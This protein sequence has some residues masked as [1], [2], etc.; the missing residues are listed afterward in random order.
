MGGSKPEPSAS[1]TPA[2]ASAPPKKGFFQRANEVLSAP[3]DDNAVGRY[4]ND[5]IDNP[6]LTG[7]EKA[8]Q[9]GAVLASSVR[10]KEATAESIAAAQKAMP[11]EPEYLKQADEVFKQAHG[12]LGVLDA[13]VSN[14]RAVLAKSIQGMVQGGGVLGAS[15]GAG[16][17]AGGGVASLL[18][19]AAGGAG[20]GYLDTYAETVLSTLQAH[21]VDLSSKDAVLQA[22]N[23][24]ALMSAASVAA[25]KAG[26]PSAIINGLSFGLA[27]RIAGP[28]AGIVGRGIAGRA[29]GAGAE[30][31]AQG[32]IGAGGE[33]GTQLAQQGAI[34]NPN[35]IAQAGVSQAALTAPFVAHGVFHAGEHGPAPQPGVEP[36]QAAGAPETANAPL[37]PTTEADRQAALSRA[38]Q[39]GGL[40]QDAEHEEAL[41]PNAQEREVARSA[42][43][44]HF[45][46]LAAVDQA[47][48][49]A[50]RAVTEAGPANAI[51]H[52]QRDAAAHV[53]AQG[54][55][56]LS[57]VVAATHA[58]AV[59]GGVHDAAAVQGA[60][61]ATALSHQQQADANA[62]AAMSQ[63]PS[64]DDAFALREAQQVQQRDRDF[65]AAKNQVGDQAIEAGD[66]SMI[67]ADRGGANE[68]KPTLA[69]ALPPE[70]LTALQS[71]KARRAAEMAQPQPEPT[72]VER[73]KAQAKGTEDDV[74]ELPPAAPPKNRLAAIRAAVEKRQAAQPPKVAEPTKAAEPVKSTAEPAE[75]EE[76]PASNPPAMTPKTLADRRQAQM[77][78]A[79]SAKVRGKVHEAPQEVEDRARSEGGDQARI[80]FL[81]SE[82]EATS[83]NDPDYESIKEELR[84]M[85][86]AP[87]E[88]APVA[89][90]DNPAA[91]EALETRA[92]A[93][94]PASEEAA[95]PAPRKTLALADRR[96]QRQFISDQKGR[97]RFADS[98]T[99]PRPEDVQ[100]TA[101]PDGTHVA[102][103]QNGRTVAA[104]HPNGTDLQVKSSTRPSAR[105]RDEAPARLE[106]LAQ[107]A[108]DRGGSLESG[109]RVSAPDQEAYRALSDRGYP[110]DERSNTTDPKT[111]AK[112]STSTDGV[113]RVGPR[114]MTQLNGLQLR[115]LAHTGDPVARA[116]MDRR[117]NALPSEPRGGTPEAQYVARNRDTGEE[118]ARYSNTQDANDHAQRFPQDRVAQEAPE[119]PAL[120]AKRNAFRDTQPGERRGAP[121]TK[122][123][124]TQRLQPLI[125]HVGPDRLQVHDGLQDPTVP[126]NVRDDAARYNHPDPR[127]A[128]DPK[129]GAVH[130]F[131]GA[132]GH[133]DLESLHDT[134]IHEMAHRGIRSFLGPDYADTMQ[135]VFDN[136]HDRAGA[137]RSP[138]AGVA[139]T[140]ARNW[141]E[142]YISQH[143]MDPKNPGHQQIAADEYVASIAEHDAND[144]R[145]RNP[146]ILRKVYD[147]V[148]AGLRKVGVVHEWT[149]NDIRRLL[150]ES[151]NNP[152][153]PHA[154]AAMED[155]GNGIRWADS[156]DR[157]VERLPPEDPRAIAAKYQRALADSANYNP[158]YVKSRVDALAR[159]KDFLPDWADH[160]WE[161][162]KDGGRRLWL[163]SIPLDKL[164]D[165]VNPDLNPSVRRYVRTVR[166][167]NGRIGEQ[168]AAAHEIYK[169]WNEFAQREPERAASLDD[170]MHESTLAG[171]DP[172]KPFEN[173]FTDEQRARSPKKTAADAARKARYDEMRPR[174]EAL[175]DEGQKIYRDVRD[176]YKQ[177]RADHDA[178]LEQRMKDLG[179][180]DARSKQLMS[181][182]Q[183]DTHES[184]RVPEPYFPLARWG[185]RYAVA[186]LAG[187]DEVH[188]Y[189]RFET[190][191]QQKQWAD[192]M[193]AE[194]HDVTE[195]RDT[196]SN[197]AAS[198]GV[199]PVFLH[200]V[201]EL[202]K[203]FEPKEGSEDSSVADEIYQHYLQSL[204]DR[205]YRKMFMHRTGRLGFAGNARRAFADQSIRH[206]KAVAS[207]EYGHRLDATLENVSTEQK[208]IAQLASSNPG[209]R[210]LQREAAW[211][212]DIRNELQNR[213][214][215]I[216]NPGSNR[217][218]NALTGFGF[219]YYL[220]FNPATAA[221]IHT[222]QYI[223]ALPWLGARHGWG[224][225]ADAL[226]TAMGQFAGSRGNFGD[227]LRGDERRAWDEMRD[228]GTFMNT[229]A[230]S[231]TSAS[232][233]DALQRSGTSNAAKWAARANFASTAMFNGIE[234][235]NRETTAM[236]AY[237]LARQEG[238]GH[239]AALEH[240]MTA[241][242]TTHFD[243]SPAN[244][245]RVLQ[246]QAGKVGGLF[247]Q[248]SVHQAY[249]I[250]RDARDGLLGN[251]NISPDER[252]ARTGT[253]A[254]MIGMSSLI[255]G[256][257]TVAT[258]VFG[259]INLAVNA[260]SDEPSF[261]SKAATHAY[262]VQHLGS[263]F[264]ADAIMSGPIS[265][266]TG[267]SLGSTGL[268]D[269]FHR[270]S[271]GDT[272]HANWYTRIAPYVPVF[273]SMLQGGPLGELGQDV[274]TAV[275]DLREGN[276]ERAIEHLLPMGFRGVPKALRHAL[277]GEQSPSALPGIE[278]AQTAPKSEFGVRAFLSQL[279][280]FTPLSLA[281]RREENAAKESAVES[282][283]GAP[284]TGGPRAQ[285]LHQ[286]VM[287][288]VKGD[289]KALDAAIA[290]AQKFNAA[291]PGMAI[292][293]DTVE[294]SANAQQQ[295]AQM[296]VHGVTIPKGM[297][298]RLQ[299]L[300]SQ[301]LEPPDTPG[302]A[303]GATAPA[304]E[305]PQ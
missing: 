299:Q 103:T 205:S 71:L 279:A 203:D 140:T 135:S 119:Q 206:A 284:G 151:N 109:P 22:L 68:P 83:P 235:F 40:L 49:P 189:S 12:F 280:N 216:R 24:P 99:R 228:N 258:P 181:L 56:A 52:G 221:R 229:Q 209:N 74:Q 107:V 166:R 58:G 29:A 147:A 26:V 240:A 144:P 121:I 125:D 159:L 304:N 291:N 211:A 224:P 175:G 260:G 118:T 96:A 263:K 297:R 232:R 122:E 132:G 34:T 153:S 139:K 41:G 188:S 3:L 112:T 270:E 244:R 97:A 61:E 275:S 160:A 254:G 13:Y 296:Q 276:T 76:Q 173:R 231:L 163:Y 251:R 237:R 226:K 31:V 257:G 182:L 72:V 287:A 293:S 171:A 207:I 64:A 30:V 70:Q 128:F 82:L 261:D 277:Y 168:M 62:Q 86:H 183:R 142:D 130:V 274:S 60:R 282:V 192:A 269:V 21:G 36:A 259:A 167:M 134:A 37:P 204:P 301:D 87:D 110:V 123:E 241:S 63:P 225:A 88:A 84:G 55:D 157:S 18:G 54:G 38:A 73:M 7:A 185:D 253:L 170:L 187:T 100:H 219:H 57:Q 102:D 195:G 266:A 133:P 92:A 247:A 190:N 252:R 101:Q 117:L 234:H 295:N 210:Y 14:P 245:P 239:G 126:Q 208:K 1:P 214:A 222:Q 249:R 198:H 131:A 152:A 162:A 6:A 4:L 80:E 25:H 161:Q 75:E 156:P 193:R 191:R 177:Q 281:D 114:D 50:H 220:G 11:V 19:A 246:G 217:F 51:E 108:H 81:Q 94:E 218:V 124:A 85:G 10:S 27:G 179:M 129:T 78:A 53:A 8:R 250:V 79:R 264:L 290:Q 65:L 155:F 200:K 294:K 146:S 178:A 5:T 77:D 286:L 44:D 271:S 300:Y 180:S 105:G 169:P 233:G 90:G 89:P 67:G 46:P 303:T 273:G 196:G 248:Y 120:A 141:M 176:A 292:D 95:Q 215:A 115:R 242:D 111:G 116:E 20:A 23:D 138:I 278:N 69:A 213:H 165:H 164:P 184:G 174:F 283:S 289:D 267:A 136:I 201:L 66:R 33:A 255:A 137:L 305:N 47:V 91:R 302:D 32:A 28:V 154:R 39:T 113:Y 194:G 199:D 2:A 186:K 223:N 16:A 202:T 227:V 288:A 158:G 43:E 145:Q 243:Y 42:A 148:R 268:W 172:S 17:V 15:A 104:D 35:A 256:A 298:D 285:L 262:L 93:G 236:A 272:A 106:K 150:R 143:A 48:A 230:Q 45:E 149:D 265:A 197:K 98:N 127:A 238:S 59:L 212:P 9:V